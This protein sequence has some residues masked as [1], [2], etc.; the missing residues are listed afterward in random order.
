MS[1]V[2]SFRDAREHKREEKRAAVKTRKHPQGRSVRAF[3]AEVAWALVESGYFDKGS[4]LVFGDALEQLL[5][6]ST[7]AYRKRT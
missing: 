4:A 3:G 5:Q 2:G 6:S 7:P 1:N